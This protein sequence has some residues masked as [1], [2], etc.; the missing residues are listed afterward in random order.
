[1][2]AQRGRTLQAAWALHPERFVHGTPKPAPLPEA[3]WIN[4]PATS[5]T[6]ETSQLNRNRRCL[7][8]VDRFRWALQDVGKSS[9]TKAWFGE[10]HSHWHGD[11]ADLSKSGKEAAESLD[12]KVLV[13]LAEL[14]GLRKADITRVKAF[15][16]R[17]D[18]GQ[19]RRAFARIT[20]PS[21]RRCVF[22][23]TAN[24]S[25][26]GV[27]PNDSSGNRR[28][29]PVVLKHEA[30]VEPVAD[31][32]RCMWWAECLERYRGGERGNLPRNLKE[33]AAER[34]EEHRAEDALEPRTPEIYW[35]TSTHKPGLYVERTQTRCDLCHGTSAPNKPDQSRYA[36]A[37]Q[38]RPRQKAHEASPGPCCG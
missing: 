35:W 28:L 17:Q 9:F 36:A 11:G 12:G 33:L 26:L 20:V 23:G 1:M 34:A 15:L 6:G 8:V 38:P 37:P 19:F 3:V 30:H 7:K 21:P 31:A 14:D 2:L 10:D 4:P 29:I 22:V 25:E 16:S 18:D 24:P 27:L 13:E 5:T 32:E